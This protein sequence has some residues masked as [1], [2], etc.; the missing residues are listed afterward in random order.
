MTTRTRALAPAR[1]IILLAAVA[2][3]GGLAGAAGAAGPPG[4]KTA[5][6]SM[7]S[8]VAPRAWVDPIMSVGDD[9]GAYQFESIPDGIS[10]RNA[11]GRDKAEV[12]VNHETSTVPFPYTA[13]GP[14]VANSQNDFDNA[15]LSRLIIDTDDASVLQASLAIASAE[16]YQRFCSNFLATKVNGFSRDLLFTNEEA[17]DWVKRTGPTFWPAT[18]GAADARQSGVVVALDPRTGDRRPIWG[19]GR[20]N[21]ENSLAVT[22]YKKPVVLSGD[23]TFVNAPSQSQ[24]YSYIATDANAVWNDTGD[25]WAFVSDD[26]L[27][28]KYEDFILNDATSVAGHFIKVPKL[29][30]TGRNPN[31]T[32]VLSTDAETALGLPAGTFAVPTDG[33]FSRPPGVT[34]GPSVDGPQWVLERWSQ[35]NGVFRFIRLEDMAYDKRQ[36]MSNVVYVVDSGRGAAGAVANGKSTNGRVWKMV[37]DK[38]DPTKVTSLS[39]LIEGDDSPVKTIG[40]IH[41]PDNIESTKRGLYIT[42]DPGSSQQFSFTDPAQV[43]D[44]NRTP[45]RIWQ[46]KLSGGATSVVAVVDQSADEAAGDVDTT[47][48]GNFGAWEASGIVDV[49]DFFGAG[50]FLVTVQAHTLFVETAP[51]P[52]LDPSVAG[53]DWLNKR[54]GGQLILLRIPGA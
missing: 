8:P 16:G 31:G 38:I 7:L 54:E 43:N 21:H 51:G 18:E 30:A 9:I 2:L 1:L 47:A 48:R 20:L 14:S 35:L 29:I 22:G 33:S 32:D 26:P 53:P 24:M 5:Q 40:E 42:E 10:I 41:Q 17:V 3:V 44:P 25:L 13:T 19:M 52:D 6:G 39:I 4:F 45:A 28:Q 36:G 27:K 46:Y 49:S 11:P 37:L 12:Y 34:T 50:T 23:D 15:Q